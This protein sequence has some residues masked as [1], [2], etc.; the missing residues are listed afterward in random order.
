MEKRPRSGKLITPRLMH[1]AARLH[2]LDGLAQVEVARRMEVS[3]ATVSRLLAQARAEGLVRIEVVDLEEA[4]DLG[5]R[6]AQALGLK[7]VRVVEGGASVLGE[8]VGALLRGAERGEGAVLAVGWGRT[9]HGMIS[10]GLPACPGL[11]VIPAMGGLDETEAHFQINEFVRRAAEQLGGS[12]RLLFAPSMVS[13]ELSAMLEQDPGIAALLDMWGRVDAAILGVGWFEAGQTGVDL[14]FDPGAA[15]QV[16][17]DVVRHYFD[18]AGQEVRWHGQDRLL[19]IRRDQLAQVPLSIGV[20]L[21][22]D[23]A[24]AILGAV[25]SGMINALVTDAQAAV[26]LLERTGF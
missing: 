24:T 5:A 20:A 19:S 25:R 12:A 14:S 17:G 15:S 9:I 23:K 18:Q 10:A 3:T 4:D 7:T 8:E 26:A 21:G 16:V 2:Y 13:P 11:T 6:L 1:R 22:R